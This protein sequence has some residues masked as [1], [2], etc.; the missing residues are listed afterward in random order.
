MSS[1]KDCY[2]G[3]GYLAKINFPSILLPYGG[4]P[5]IVCPWKPSVEEDLTLLISI[6]CWSPGLNL[7]LLSRVYWLSKLQ[8]LELV[9]GEG[10][11]PVI[12]EVLMVTY[13][14]WLI[15][16]KGVSTLSDFGIHN[17]A[18]MLVCL[19]EGCNETRSIIC[20]DG[21]TKSLCQ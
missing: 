6:F 2:G 16:H 9:N 14:F 20:G 13:A 17:V 10:R 4:L 8:L 21:S 1:F 15:N 11:H 3:G 18:N 12:A 19:V 7:L 5:W